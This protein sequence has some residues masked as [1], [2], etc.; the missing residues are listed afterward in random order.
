[1]FNYIIL[2]FAPQIPAALLKHHVLQIG[3]GCQQHGAP[4]ARHTELGLQG[5]LRDLFRH[6]QNHTLNESGDGSFSTF[7]PSREQ[8]VVKMNNHKCIPEKSKYSVPISF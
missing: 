4:E 2:A 3:P 8:R 5:I 7:A 1:M 6:T